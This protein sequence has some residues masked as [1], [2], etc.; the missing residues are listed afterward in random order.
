MKISIIIPVFNGEKYITKCVDS[1][2]QEKQY[3]KEIDVVIVDD[4]S[5]DGTYKLSEQLAQ[6]YN[7]VRVFYK[8]NGGVSSA[9]NLGLSV[10]C[11]Q[12][13]LFVDADDGH[14]LDFSLHD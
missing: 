8:E 4:G 3:Q 5:I 9:R 6:R 10:A 1:I 12:F 13:V 14:K 2:E 11:G 7:N